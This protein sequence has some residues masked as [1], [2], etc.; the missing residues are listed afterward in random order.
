MSLAIRRADANDADF[1]AWTILT[2]QRGHRPRGFFD[3]ALGLSEAKCLA[4]VRRVALAPTVSQWHVST[5]WI[6][7]QDG[8]AAA[9]I[10]ALPSRQA[11]ET[12]RTAI[13]EAA[14]EA[15]LAA[16]DLDEISK[17]GAYARNC[18]TWGGDDTWMLEH[19]ATRP[20]HRGQGLM[21]ALLTHAL[22]QGQTNGFQRASIG[23]YIGNNAAE[24]CYAKAGFSSAQEKRDREFEV[25]TGSP[26]FRRF[27]RA[28]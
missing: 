16:S 22:A 8:I 12:V 20:S 2:A 6:A 19:V 23:F 27:E 11:R 1:V 28:I 5:F 21:S 13:E 4:F 10:C 14:N 25:L 7:E 9:A 24:R 18:W 3:I 17:R 26:G 15:G